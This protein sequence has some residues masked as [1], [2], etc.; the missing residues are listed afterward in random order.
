MDTNTVALISTKLDATMTSIASKAGVAVDHF[1]PIFVRQQMI[2]GIC[3]FALMFFGILIVL[4]CLK[5]FT[6]ADKNEKESVACISMI[7][8]MCIFVITSAFIFAGF[9]D[10]LSKVINPEYA[11]VQ[12]IIQMVK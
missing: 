1:W 9:S 4:I 5:T 10:A 2:E 11:A 7:V 8:G 12:S 3:N 6:W